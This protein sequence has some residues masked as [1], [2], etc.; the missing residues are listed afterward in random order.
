[1]YDGLKSY[2]DG[3]GRLL[4]LG[5]NGIFDSVDLSDDLVTM[6]VHGPESARTAEFRDIGRPEAELL[7]VA[8]TKNVDARAP[9]A[10]AWPGHPLLEGIRVYGRRPI[11]TRALAAGDLIGQEGWSTHFGAVALADGAASGFEVDQAGGGTYPVEVIAR[12]TNADDL[13]RADMVLYRYGGD[14]FVFSVGSI[15]FGGSLVV[16]P[17]LQTIVRNALDAC[18]AAGFARRILEFP[19]GVDPLGDW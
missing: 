11:N 12:G 2:L 7:G 9:Y 14:G 15:A 6:T 16:D 5:G 3:G 18:L 17:I 10:V 13:E 1:M 4:Y 19:F 8:Y